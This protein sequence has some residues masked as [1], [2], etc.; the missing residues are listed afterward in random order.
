MNADIDDGAISFALTMKDMD[1]LEFLIYSHR[2]ESKNKVEFLCNV[3]SGK[4]ECVSYDR[5][6]YRRA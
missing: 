4:V 6:L 2:T 3:Q 5:Y 1:K